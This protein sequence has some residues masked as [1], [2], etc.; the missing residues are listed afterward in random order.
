MPVSEDGR[1]EKKQKPYCSRPPRVH[2]LAPVCTPLP[3]C[4]WALAKEREKTPDPPLCIASVPCARPPPPPVHGVSTPC[5][6]AHV[7]R[8]GQMTHVPLFSPLDYKY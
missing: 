6:R 8:S 4:A 1:E 5:A 7:S 2:G 3:P